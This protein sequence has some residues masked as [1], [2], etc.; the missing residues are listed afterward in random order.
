MGEQ[1]I[2]EESANDV[3]SFEIGHEQGLD[4]GEELIRAEHM[5]LDKTDKDSVGSPDFTTGHELLRVDEVKALNSMDVDGRAENSI[6]GSEAMVLPRDLSGP[7]MHNLQIGDMVWGKVK[8]HPWWPGHIF[9]EAFASPL[10]RR[11]KREGHV[12]VAFFGDSSYGWFDPEELIPFE[13][14]YAEKSKQTN[15]RTFLKAVE[16]ATDE[17][18]RRGA[19]AVTCNCRNQLN[20]RNTDVLG[21]YAVDVTG[22]EPCGIYSWP[23]IE[24]ARNSFVP[25][26]L[27]S[28][29]RKLAQNPMRCVDQHRLDIE[30]VKSKAMDLA[31]RRAV[32][33]EHDET[34]AQAFGIQPVLPSPNESG[35]PGQTDRFAPRAVPLSGSLV[36]AETLGDKKASTVTS[37]STSTTSTTSIKP[38]AAAHKSGKVSTSKKNKYEFKRREEPHYSSNLYYFPPQQHGITFGT[39]PQQQQN[40]HHHVSKDEAPDSRQTLPGD[41][42]LQ[43]RSP[44]TV[45]QESIKN[46]RDDAVQEPMPLLALTE[47]DDTIGAA[48]AHASLET[49]DESKPQDVKAVIALDDGAFAGVV[50][51]PDLF[52]PAK[53]QALASVDVPGPETGS[54]NF[55]SPPTTAQESKSAE[56][57]KV[58]KAPKRKR[59][60]G[61]PS[62]QIKKKK[63]KKKDS[64][65][66]AGPGPGP[67]PGPERRPKKPA[68][69]VVGVS[70]GFG[71]PSRTETAQGDL[72]RKEVVGNTFIQLPKVDI[73]SM[74]IKLPQVITDLSVLAIEPFYGSE[75]NVPSIVSHI[76]LKFRSLVYQ[77]SLVLPQASETVTPEFRAS[78]LAAERA[79][80]EPGNANTEIVAAK[81]PREQREPALPSS[82]KPTKPRM[83]PEDPTKSG[84]KRGPSSRQEEISVKRVKKLTQVKTL[85]TEKKSVL[86]Q[87]PPERIRQEQETPTPVAPLVRAASKPPIARKEET[88]N[89]PKVVS[90]TYLVMKFPPKS[91]LPSVASMKAKFAR[92]GTL[93][94][95]A[96]RV[97]WKS[98]TCKVL[99]KYRVDAVAAYSHCKSNQTY[100]PRVNYSIRDADSSVSETP[101][102]AKRQ[103]TKAAD[104]TQFGTGNGNATAGMSLNPLR[105]S[106]R[107]QTGQPKSILKKP[108]DVGGSG[109]GPAKE[110]QRVKFMLGGDDVR[111][112][113]PSVVASNKTGGIR[114]ELPIEPAG[115]KLNSENQ[116]PPVQP[117]VRPSQPQHYPPQLHQSTHLSELHRPQ[118]QQQPPR[119]TELHRPQL[120]QPRMSELHLPQLQQSRLSELHHPQLQQPPR[121]SELHHHHP[122]FQQTHRQ[123]EMYHPQFQQPSRL[124]EM[125]HRMHGPPMLHPRATSNIEIH[126]EAEGITRTDIPDFIRQGMH[127]LVLCNDIVTNLKPVLGSRRYQPL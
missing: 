96:I 33:E 114:V 55:I 67:G 5:A 113:P 83:R 24:K 85:T 97:Y 72:H 56:G 71:V 10:V 90:P 43:K 49:L 127:L 94:I 118:H 117:P 98:L 58:L 14:H 124:P 30:T 88:L 63:T 101:D 47:G 123:P 19:L 51:E 78:K 35:G 115:A 121:L 2:N 74:N 25:S 22:Y 26:C 31:Y 82:V 73:G 54:M 81:D 16:E 87:K 112:E 119:L 59:E 36:I 75:L 12:L 70:V 110:T 84:R 11:T 6:H 38:P 102:S 45:Q 60:D 116:L 39:I 120:Q 4:L 104:G 95:D 20:L 3:P 28:F 8:S 48:G 37:I 41:Y 107:P 62:G 105:P 103:E 44:P 76:I 32:F 29:V 23:Q 111:K 126:R 89:H 21:F 80:P 17:A 53:V 69:K 66:A 99:F 91:T 50:S 108:D 100:G 27:L 92:F 64:G 57:V 61:I 65:I 77:K 68:G 86:G 93:E 7:W 42:V 46:E 15:S 9:N 18:S 13:P 122:Q 52:S 109:S 40:V 79:L 106:L 1:E 34:Y 125:H